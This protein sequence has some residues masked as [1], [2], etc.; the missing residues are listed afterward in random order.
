MA[1][2]FHPK[3]IPSFV[4][5]YRRKPKL[6]LS[7]GN[8]GMK[9]VSRGAVVYTCTRIHAEEMKAIKEVRNVRTLVGKF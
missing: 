3:K 4:S 8:K 1:D 9:V 6:T 7:Q 5:V 2:M